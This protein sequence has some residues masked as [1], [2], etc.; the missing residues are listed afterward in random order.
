MNVKLTRVVLP[1]SDRCGQ[2]AGPS[3]GLTATSASLAPMA[4]AAGQ[5]QVRMGRARA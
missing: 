4:Y 2:S 1:E 5:F 3:R